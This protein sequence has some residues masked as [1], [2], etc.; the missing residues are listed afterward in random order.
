M[1]FFSRLFAR[2]LAAMVSARLLTQKVLVPVCAVSINLLAEELDVTMHFEHMLASCLGSG[3][4]IVK[5]LKRT[6]ASTAAQK[7]GPAVGPLLSL[8]AAGAIV[9]GLSVEMHLAR[10]FD[11]GILG[12][13]HM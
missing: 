8:A 10:S 4:M 5:R 3:N 6:V 11:S 9:N 12:E 2:R 13:L 1:G 7:V